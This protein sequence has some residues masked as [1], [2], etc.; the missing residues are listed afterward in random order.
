M[1]TSTAQPQSVILAGRLPDGV[2]GEVLVALE[3]AEVGVG[4]DAHGIDPEL[5]G[6]ALVVEGVDH[7]AD[8]VVHG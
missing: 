8:V 4:L 2:P 5:E 3:L 7:E 6:P 1:A